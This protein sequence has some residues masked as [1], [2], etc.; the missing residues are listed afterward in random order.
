MC[1]QYKLDQLVSPSRLGE[2]CRRRLSI[3]IRLNGAYTSPSIPDLSRSA[4]GIIAVK[5]PVAREDAV[6]DAGAGLADAVRALRTEILQAI[7]EGSQQWMRFSLEPIELTLQA[8]V[9]K[10]GD[11][12]IGWKILEFGGKY[13]SEVTQT[14]KL[15]LKPV[16]FRPDGTST[17]DFTI[18][19]GQPEGFTIG[20]RVT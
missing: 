19:G 9:T 1:W 10:E 4:G 3:Q 17:T 7:N 16:W 14:V 5:G 2:G 12:K 18:A 20:R 8:V 13:Q 11:G 6:S 15:T